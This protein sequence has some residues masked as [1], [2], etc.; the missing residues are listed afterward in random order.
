ML[1]YRSCDTQHNGTANISATLE[2]CGISF[3]LVFQ[4]DVLALADK[5]NNQRQQKWS[6]FPLVPNPGTCRRSEPE[7]HLAEFYTMDLQA[8]K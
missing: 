8:T 4:S 5:I 2:E 1:H 6:V 3:F 7:N